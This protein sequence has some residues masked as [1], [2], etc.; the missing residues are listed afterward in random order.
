[1][2][3]RRCAQSSSYIG[4]GNMKTKIALVGGTPSERWC[5]AQSEARNSHAS[6]LNATKF[7]Q[8]PHNNTNTTRA[9]RHATAYSTTRRR[10][11]EMRLTA[12]ARLGVFR[13]PSF[14][15]WVAC[16]ADIPLFPHIT[17]PPPPHPLTNCM[18]HNMHA[19]SEHVP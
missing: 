2:S 17:H 9:H 13:A 4:R 14:W 5:F 3:R 1:M 10:M 16:S 19:I 8:S 15:C 18:Y 6:C 11:A 7:S 12:R